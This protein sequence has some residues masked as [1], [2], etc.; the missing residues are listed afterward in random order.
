MVLIR[1]P[2]KQ[3]VQ[4][5]YKGR[6]MYKMRTTVSTV[7]IPALGHSYGSWTVTKARPVL[8]PEQKRGHV[9][10]ADVLQVRRVRYLQ[11]DIHSMVLI[12]LPKK[13]HVQQPVQR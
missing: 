13:Q 5:R 12:R 3:H 8:L 6:K 2:K 11:Q 10:E 1:L 9:P 4:Q 7:E